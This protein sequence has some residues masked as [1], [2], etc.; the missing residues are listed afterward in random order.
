MQRNGFWNSW[1]N[2]SL[3][4][5]ILFGGVLGIW[6]ELH[7]SMDLQPAEISALVEEARIDL[8]NQ[9]ISSPTGNNALYK[10]RRVLA[11]Q[12]DH[13]EALELL[14]GCALTY[15][16]MA[17]S[18]MAQ[19]D[20]DG[21]A[22]Y[23]FYAQTLFPEDRSIRALGAGLSPSYQEMLNQFRHSWIAETLSNA[24]LNLA[25]DRLTRPAERNA[26]YRYRQVLEADPENNRALKGLRQVAD[27]LTLLSQ[28]QGIDNRSAATLEQLARWIE[29]THPNIP[30]SS[31]TQPRTSDSQPRPRMAAAPVPSEVISTTTPVEVA[32]PEASLAGQLPAPQPLKKSP[33]AQAPSMTDAVTPQP[34]LAEAEEPSPSEGQD[35]EMVS[36]P[37]KV[38][39]DFITSLLNR[40]EAA[41]QRERMTVPY[42]L[43]ALYFYRQVLQVD[44][45]QPVAKQGLERIVAHLVK[46]AK[47]STDQHTAEI[48]LRR[49]AAI[50]PQNAVVQQALNPEPSAQNRHDS[51]RATVGEKN[52]AHQWIPKLLEEAESLLAEDRLTRPQGRNALFRFR[53][54]LEL[55]PQNPAAQEGIQKVA[56]RLLK[57][58]EAEVLTNPQRALEHLRNA[59]Q[60]DPN[61]PA[62][63]AFYQ[64][65]A[66]LP[67]LSGEA[68]LEG[69][70][71]P[72]AQV[73]AAPLSTSTALMAEP[74]DEI[75]RLLNDGRE[76][77][78]NDRLTMPPRRNAQYYFARLLQLD[79]TNPDGVDGLR[80]VADR[81]VELASSPSTNTVTRGLMLDKAKS[82]YTVIGEKEVVHKGMSPLPPAKQ[83]LSP[84]PVNTQRVAPSSPTPEPHVLVEP[85]R[86]APEPVTTPAKALESWTE[87]NTN[88]RFI[89]IPGGCFNMGSNQ[90]DDDEKPIHRACVDGF[91]LGQF[92]I[93]QAQWKLVM[94]SMSN[95]SKQKVSNE[96]PVNNI[97]WFDTREFIERLSQLS[98]EKF[99]LPSE[100]EW[101]YACRSGGKD[102][103]WSG[104]SVPHSVAWVSRPGEKLTGTQPVGRKAP[105]GF[106]L[107]DMS[108]NVYEWVNDWYDPNFYANAPERNPVSQNSDTELRILRGGAWLTGAK[109][110]RCADREWLTP[111]Q[112]FD[113]TG[114]RLVREP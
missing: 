25:E 67:E 60:L 29:H 43:S 110:S 79:P 24:D 70:P 39:K 73:E 61:N 40:A 76:A 34:L 38:D 78:V 48:Y 105:N 32:E 17:K 65:I 50:L 27:R 85:A 46:L 94:G 42:P 103:Q 56:A 26:L 58:A 98:G 83:A 49:A 92:E 13:H 97:S 82:I 9:R 102:E 5:M 59:H 55:E 77:L 37:L 52:K 106:G 3:R 113:V 47:E 36:A 16:E 23:L 31:F 2:R 21:A 10:L 104:S 86:P 81:L 15:A 99:R 101:E 107:F 4:W 111:D 1:L 66:Q 7:A 51:S 91:W 87:K 84:A 12:S 44:P 28:E 35:R 89:R 8:A 54:V 69:M 11:F 114:F 108:G 14:R 53:Q 6:G 71:T 64:R 22:R 63:V 57:L 95:P 88:M 45:Q 93:T 20:P 90:G 74:L 112:W 96:N 68:P 72:A 33:V 30:P 19:G 100:T 41:M 18:Y 109:Q 62:I 80:G 75:G